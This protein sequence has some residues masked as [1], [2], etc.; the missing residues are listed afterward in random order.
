MSTVLP[1]SFYYATM[2]KPEPLLLITL[3]GYFYFFKKEKYNLSFIFAGLSVG[4][5]ISALLII[6]PFFFLECIKKNNFSFGNFFEKY[7]IGFALA[8]PIFLSFYACYLSLKIKFKSISKKILFYLMI[9]CFLLFSLPFLYLYLDTIITNTFHGDNTE[10]VG[11]FEWISYIVEV[12]F[13]SSLIISIYLLIFFLLIIL[14]FSLKEFPLYKVINNKYCKI[15]FAVAIFKIFFLLTIVSRLW[16][17][18]LYLPTLF[19]LLGILIFYEQLITNKLF[20]FKEKI[21][22]HLFFLP[23]L[24]I[25]FLIWSI[26]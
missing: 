8:N 14:F 2:P 25:L 22:S 18:Y 16:G 15:L 6:I 21:Y 9:L 24:L 4:V 19:F 1:Y 17:F 26:R 5:K 10:N 13:N 11:Y 3:F 23:S 20:S 7:F 12:Y